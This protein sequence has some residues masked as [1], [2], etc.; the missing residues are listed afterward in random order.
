[1]DAWHRHLSKHIKNVRF[2]KYQELLAHNDRRMV[3][4]VQWGTF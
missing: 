4:V 1:V 3:L 2:Q